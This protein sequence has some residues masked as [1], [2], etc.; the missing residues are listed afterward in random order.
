MTQVATLRA[1]IAIIRERAEAATPGRRQVG[2]SWVAVGAPAVLTS[3]GHPIADC[4]VGPE[5]ELEMAHIATWSREAALAV[6]DLLDAIAQDAEDNQ[7]FDGMDHGVVFP[8][9][10]IAL[11]LAE[12]IVGGAA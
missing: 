10:A 5:A 6:A 11:R 2:P 3:A 4:G 7:E 1:A 8:P 9:S 12:L